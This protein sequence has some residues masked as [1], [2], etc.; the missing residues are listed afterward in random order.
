M[1]LRDSRIFLQ[2]VAKDFRQTGA[3]APSS[4]FL[5]IAMTSELASNRGRPL[6]VLEVGGGTGSITAVIVRQLRRGDHLHVVEIDASFASIIRHR[7]EENGSLRE[8]GISI[9]VSN[10]PIQEMERRDKY[11]FLV[12]CLPFTCFDAGTV[13]RIFEIYRELLKPGGSCSFY[14]YILVRRAAEF[15]S[16]T[17][18]ERER[19][20]DVARVV[21]DYRTRFCYKREV[22]MCNLPPA[23]VCHLRFATSP[24]EES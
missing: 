17:A 23:W 19:V 6:R 15:I 21:E 22:V 12:S 16:G 20:R 18:R 24:P 9:R 7:F 13:K 4:R 2:N 14:E 3:I 10:R 1:H 8:S 5:G 11:D